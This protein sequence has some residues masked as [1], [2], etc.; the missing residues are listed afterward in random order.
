[1]RELCLRLSRGP[2]ECSTAA[3]IE[4]AQPGAFVAHRS[5]GTC[6]RV[7]R[8]WLR[9][10]LLPDA[11]QQFRGERLLL[12]L[13][14]QRLQYHHPAQLRGSLSGSRNS[15]H[16]AVR[17][18]LFHKSESSGNFATG[19][20]TTR[21]RNIRFSMSVSTALSAFQRAF[22]DLPQNPSSRARDASRNPSDFSFGPLGF[23]FRRG[24]RRHSLGSSSRIAAPPADAVLN[25]LRR[26]IA[27]K[28]CEQLHCTQLVRHP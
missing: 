4:L 9:A 11:L 8:I 21:V 26:S 24:C 5:S 27:S 3:R 2:V 13:G 18:T 15:V 6:S 28:L 7:E 16:S 23:P 19:A 20:R 22:P 25:M 14:N 12:P 17:L 1:M 10:N